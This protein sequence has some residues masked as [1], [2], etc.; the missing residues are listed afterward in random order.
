ML[1]GVEVRVVP[2]MNLEIM[3]TGPEGYTC[4]WERILS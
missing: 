2:F 1:G 3:V 4:D